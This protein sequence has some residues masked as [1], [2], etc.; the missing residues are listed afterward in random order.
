MKIPYYQIN[1]FTRDLFGGNPAGVCPLD[2]W[3]E[4]EV[5]QAV[6]AENGLSE[7]AFLVKSDQGY[8]L[9]WFTPEVEIDLCGHATLA[10]AYVVFNHLEKDLGRV[11]FFTRSGPLKVLGR[12]DGILAMDFPARPG[13]SCPAVEGLAEGLGADPD[14]IH[15][16]RDVMAVF[17]SREIVERLRPD[18]DTLSKIE[19]TGII[20]TAPGDDCD[21]VS[22]F[23]APRVGIDEDPVTGSAHCTLVPYWAGRL[24]KRSLHAKQVS[25]RGGELFCEHYG[26]RVLIAGHAVPYLQGE[27]IID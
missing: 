13:V 15:I 4:D 8:D 12:E 1:A 19:S 14:E 23:F 16:S 11:Q 3:I 18:F 10:S 27:I 5:M 2:D 9:R 24:K 21:F 7:T 22:R 6:A 20:I 26:E 25:K 17:E